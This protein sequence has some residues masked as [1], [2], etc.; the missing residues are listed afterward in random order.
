MSGLFGGNSTNAAQSPT[1]TG[2]DVNTSVYGQVVQVVYGAQ[3]VSGNLIWY[4]DFVQISGSGSKGGGKGGGGSGGKAG[5]NGAASTV[6]EPQYAFNAS[7]IKDM[8]NVPLFIPGAA[9]AGINVEELDFGG[10]NPEQPHDA[11]DTGHEQPHYDAER[12][13][14]Q[15]AEQSGIKPGWYFTLRGGI[16]HGPFGSKEASAR[17]LNEMIEQ[18][19][20]TG[21]TGGR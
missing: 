8:F 9:N 19:K 21:D 1:Y 6:D 7:E 15:S 13:F 14:Y 12:V 20:R 10:L 17:V 4:G 5:G 18:F 16:T 11:A 3:R 2:I